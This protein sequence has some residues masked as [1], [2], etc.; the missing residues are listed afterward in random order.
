M[1]YRKGES[2]NPQGRPK[3]VA[4]KRTRRIAENVARLLDGME[5]QVK[6]DLRR[7]EPNERVKAYISLL[8]YAIPKQATITAEAK[9]QSEF[10]QLEKLLRTAPE[11]AVTAIAAKVMEMQREQVEQ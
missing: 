8:S 6:D 5:A 1:A 7:L 9:I 11:E 10:S 4:N 3:G 2:G